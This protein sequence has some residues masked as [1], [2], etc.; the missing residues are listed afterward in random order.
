[1]GHFFEPHRSSHA[2]MLA[3]LIHEGFGVG[4]CFS[5]CGA[6]NRS[7]EIR[8]FH[9]IRVRHNVPPEADQ[10]PQWPDFDECNEYNECNESIGPGSERVR[11]DLREGRGHL[12]SGARL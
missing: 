5:S 3:L 6:F 11:R 2:T 1:M 7:Y 12:G 10:Q 9:E 8:L 4:C